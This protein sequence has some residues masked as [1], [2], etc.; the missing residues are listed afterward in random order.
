MKAGA[1]HFMQQVRFD[2]IDIFLHPRMIQYFRRLP[3]E[4]ASTNMSK[5]LFA[6]LLCHEL[7]PLDVERAIAIDL[8]DIL[9][10]E[11]ILGLWNE[12]DLLQAD[13]LLA[14]ASHRAV[15]ETLRH[16]KPTTL[17][18]GLVLYEVA[19]MRTSGYTEDTLRAARGG[20]ERNYHHFCMWD[21]DIINAMHQDLWGGRRVRVLPCRWSLFPVAGWQFFWN[22][23]SFWL[24]EFIELR[25]YPGF[26]GVDHFEHFCP[27]PVLMLHSMFAF[28]SKRDRKLARDVALVQGIR[29]ELPGSSIHGPDG[30]KCLCGEKA[31][32]LHVPSTMKL[33]PW[34]QRLFSFHSPPFLPRANDAAMFQSRAE[35]GEEIGGGFWGAE[36]ERELASMRTGTFRWAMSVGATIVSQNC[37]T[38]PTSHGNYADVEFAGWNRSDELTLVA[39]TDA[40]QDAHVFIG[41]ITPVTDALYAVGLEVVVDAFNKSRTVLRWG[42][43][44]RGDELAS[45]DGSVLQVGPLALVFL[46]ETK[47]ARVAAAT[48]TS[49][50]VA[51]CARGRRHVWLQCQ[52][53]STSSL[54]RRC[55]TQNSSDTEKADWSLSSNRVQIL[56][57]LL[58]ACIANQA[59]RALPFYL[60]DFAADAQAD[61]AMNQDLAFGSSDYA[62]FATLGFTIP[63]TL[64]SLYA[65]VAADSVD[66]FRLTAAAGIGW[67]LATASMASAMSYNTLLFQR[68]VLGLFQAATNPAALSVISELFPEARATAN[69]VFGLGIYIGG[70]VASLGAAIDEQEGWRMACLGFGFVSAGAC[71]PL[72]FRSDSRSSETLQ[73]P[74][75]PLAQLQAKLVA[76]PTDAVGVITKSAEA[77]SPTSARWLLLASTL[78]FSAG[79]AIL[80]WLPTAIR[81]SFPNDVEQFAVVNSLIKAFAGGTSS[82]AGGLAADELRA[83]GFG[84]QAAALFCGV[85]SLISVPL[86][87]FTLDDGL[88]FETC[89]GFLLVEY[90]VAESWLGPAISALQGAVPAGQRGTA[91]GVFSSLTALGNGLPVFLGL[92]APSQLA[93]GLQVSVSACYLL[94]G[95]CFLMAALNLQDQ[96]AQGASHE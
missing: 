30:S 91:Q 22:T 7:L 53:A 92:L 68:A 37:A 45:Y 11:D 15:E 32:L 41:K 1:P 8:G 18:G 16:T 77:V 28:G 74:S 58:L 63:F 23:P 62:L 46:L 87:Y 78:R 39:E 72:L 19:R 61:Q 82:I 35:Q 40:S 55:C 90:L 9:V 84:D 64:A 95:V 42:M 27:G 56:A 17:N 80:V 65:G 20:L 10:F 4:C 93:A 52:V 36:G 76:L 31:A 13:E 47:G 60:V 48:S 75:D 69:S 88:S 14:A 49:L 12:G 21:Q 29:N 85:T 6:R 96:P 51:G 24:S 79:F 94:S 2:Y 67:S 33:W 71:L 44:I 54:V 86:W 25:R 5:A 50:F 38:M 26:L 66:R 89:M 83:R 59:C 34:V 73:W 70:A 81:A 3:D 43:G 57:L